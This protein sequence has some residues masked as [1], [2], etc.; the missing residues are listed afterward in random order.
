MHVFSLGHSKHPIAVFLQLLEQHA[1]EVVADVRSMPYSRFSPQFSRRALET[2]VAAAGRAYVFLGDELGGRP[3]DPA[4]Y[5]EQGRMRYGLRA[6]SPEF[7]RGIARL[8]AELAQHRVAMMCSE[9]NPEHCHRRLLV[10]RVLA[11][12][13]VAIDHI[14][15]DGR[16]EP[17]SEL[18]R[19]GDRQGALFDEVWC[20]SH[21]V[22][23]KQRS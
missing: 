13:G 6:R 9:E 7:L 23:P 12:R 16:L 14:R 20:S 11:A 8:E 5:D 4:L 18:A 3:G 2:A 21:A 15:G 17:E 22:R 10:G 1:I 19:G